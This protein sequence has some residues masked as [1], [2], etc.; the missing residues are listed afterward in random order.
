MEKVATDKKMEGVS[1]SE[2]GVATQ[3]KKEEMVI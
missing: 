1:I 3:D 2:E